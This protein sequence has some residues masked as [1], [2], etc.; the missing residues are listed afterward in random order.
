MTPP[1]SLQALPETWP[2]YQDHQHD[3]PEAAVD[4]ADVWEDLH[5]FGEADVA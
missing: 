3:D 1:F 5:P 4:C 2:C